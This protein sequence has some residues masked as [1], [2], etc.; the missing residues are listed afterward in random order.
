MTVAPDPQLATDDSAEWLVGVA[1]LPTY[2]QDSGNVYRPSVIVCLDAA[3]EL[4]VSTTVVPPDDVLGAVAA[5]L[6]T[7][8]RDP[9][10]GRLAIPGRIRVA[11]PELADVLRR[12]P[13]EG[14][15]VVCAPTPEVDRA[16]ASLIERL[17][18]SDEEQELRYLGGDATVE[19]AAALFR[20]AARLYVLK[21]WEIVLS[22]SDLIGVTSERLGLRDAVVS[23]IGQA[24]KIHGYV[25]FSSRDDFDQFS[26]AADLGQQGQSASFPSHLALTYARRADVGPLLLAEVARHRWKVAD[27]RAY[28]VVTALDEDGVGRGPTRSEMLRME[29]IAT[30][31][32]E[33]ID[34]HLH[35]LEDAPWGAPT[36]TF[37]NK[38]ETS[39]GAI[40]IEVVAPAPGGQPDDE[41]LGDDDELD[42]DRAAAHRSAILDR[43]HASPEAEAEPAAHWGAL[44][45]DYAAS[46]FARSVTSLTPDELR[47]IVFEIIP[48]KASVDPEAAPA[49]IAG[50]RAF[51]AFLGREHPASHAEA[52]LASLDGTAS[53]RLARLLADPSR[54]GPAKAFVMGGRAAGFDMS[55]QSGA[56]AW[57][58]H[59][60]RHDL[61]LPMNFPIPPAAP[62]RTAPVKP[63]EP[64]R[65]AK[66]AKRKA[67]RAARKNRSR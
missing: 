16:I 58:A 43:F 17:A 20:A 48:R 65:Q 49:I 19:G 46:Y 52:C 33:I 38:V 45:V 42:E 66:K 21:P 10:A 44:L 36:L 23:V 26:E 25:V 8:V 55:T 29:V 56:D 51:L 13:L 5:Q 67:Q 11:S 31:L 6:R 50:L 7:A 59:M 40:D 54:F 18:P 41:Q 47:E 9:V 39:G 4:I 64:S 63:P 15:E 24:G 35:E 61:R 27:A 22:D 3:T 30:A 32:A 37:H 62:R 12:E 34:K 14:V 57:A 60:R 53:Q 2:I 28:P 1:S